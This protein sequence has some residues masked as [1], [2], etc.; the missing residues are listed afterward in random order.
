M[1]ITDENQDNNNGWGSWAQR[2]F[3]Q[4]DR[5]DREIDSLDKRIDGNDVERAAIKE[6]IAQIKKEIQEIKDAARNRAIFW[7]G[8]TGTLISA[9]VAIVLFLGNRLIK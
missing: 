3:Y 9:T 6:Q 8:L 7:G 5:H 2:I 1:P 4:L